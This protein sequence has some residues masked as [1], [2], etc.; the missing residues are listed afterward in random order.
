M[1]DS[2][3]P[4]GYGGTLEWSEDAG[5]AEP[6]WTA[7]SEFKSGD[8]PTN[9][10]DKVE[11]THMSSPDMT[12]EYTFGLG[13]PQD[14]SFTFNFNS[15]DYAALFA[16]QTNRTVVTWRHTLATE[17]ET[18]NGAVY[19]YTGLVNLGSGSVT[20]E[21]ITE[22]SATIQRTGSYTFTAAT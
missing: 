6:V 16:L 7:V 13:D 18:T 19:E 8:V 3:T 10:V 15:T 20:V 11:R 22:I 14:V 9:S 21:G 5:A 12:K 17:D 2:V 4:I 1:A